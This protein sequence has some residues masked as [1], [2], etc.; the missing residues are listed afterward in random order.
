MVDELGGA[1][2]IAARTGG[3]TMVTLLLPAAREDDKADAA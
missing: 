3:G 1:V 2:T